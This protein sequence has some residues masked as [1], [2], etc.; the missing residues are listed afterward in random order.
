[1]LEDK[2]VF[3]SED[4][5]LLDILSNKAY[6]QIY[7]AHGCFFS[8]SSLSRLFEKH[9]MEIFDAEHQWVHGG[10][11]RIY[12]S[13]KGRYDITGRP[14]GYL[15]R[16]KERGIESLESFLDFSNDIRENRGEMRGL[17]KGLKM[18]GKRLVGYGAAAKGVMVQNYCKI[19]P[20][21]LDYISDSTPE[22]QGM[23]TPGMHIPIVHPDIFHED[24]EVDYAVLFPWNHA[25]EIIEKERDFFKRG[26]KFI[27]HLPHPRILELED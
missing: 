19:G 24:K 6:D 14:L 2:G 5:Y 10:S 1:M 25:R 23:F 9:N 11:M 13:K 26:G 18:A 8:I 22:K 15:E 16:E 12:V 21:I 27:V 4:P 7:E 17:L 20:D 3:I